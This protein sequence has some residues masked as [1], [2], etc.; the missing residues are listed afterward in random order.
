MHA[1]I[2]ILKHKIRIYTYTT[3]KLKNI[4]LKNK[5]NKNEK[6]MFS[7][8]SSNSRQIQMQNKS[9]QT[10]KDTMLYSQTFKVISSKWH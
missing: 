9:Y 7:K 8:E 4:N 3:H 10:A 1:Y 6:K 5:K 2:S